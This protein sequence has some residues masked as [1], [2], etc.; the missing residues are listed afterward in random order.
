MSSGLTMRFA[1]DV[2]TPLTV[3]SFWDD[4]CDQVEIGSGSFGRV[5][6][7][8]RKIDLC[9]YA[10]KEIDNEFRSERERE[11]L[12][13][14]IY[15]LSTQGDNIHV[16]RYFNAWEENDKIYIQ[17]ELCTGSLDGVRKRQGALS[18][19][20]LRVILVQVATGLSFMHHHKVA[21]LDGAIP[22]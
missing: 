5:L 2:S 17:T 6:S 18:E 14:E 20:S 13:R 12:L 4:F 11:R 22:C 8:R 9:Q 16:V 7:C 10:V 21:H 3:R 1:G 15:A 19:E